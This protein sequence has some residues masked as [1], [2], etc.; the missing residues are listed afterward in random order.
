[1]VASETAARAAPDG[2]TLV[3]ANNSSHGVNQALN[4]KVP[5]DTV[6]DFTAISLLASAPH[7]LVTPNAFPPKTVKELIALAKAKPGQINFGSAG[8]GSQTH[9]SGELFKFMT[10]TNLVHIPYSGTGPGFTALLG[11]EIQVMFASTPGSMPHVQAGRLKALGISGERRSQLLPNMPTLAEQGV[12]GFETG[13][14]YALLGPAA[15]PKSIV[16][17][18]NEEA[19]KLARSANFKEKLLSQGAEPVG[20]TPEECARIIRNELAK[21]TKVVK[22]AGIRQE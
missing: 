5:Y 10:G 20:S 8:V 12:S 18:L 11:G 22:E 16:V 4:P 1:V 15:M 19:V 14:W 3:M 2:Y 6:K 7:L 13:P 9:L 21:W 17:R